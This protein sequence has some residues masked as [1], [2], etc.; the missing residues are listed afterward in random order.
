[1]MT[2]LAASA[3]LAL[4]CLAFMQQPTE[5]RPARVGA[6][7]PTQQAQ[8]APDERAAPDRTAPEGRPRGDAASRGRRMSEALT[9]E[10]LAEVIA[11]A[12][13]ISPEW[14]EGL[15]T[16]LAEDPDGLRQAIASAGPRLVGLAMLKRSHPELYALRIGTYFAPSAPR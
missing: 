11:V 10:E 16:R 14:G 3:A 8:S 2:N 9:V 7:A 15:R 4:G 1:M 12:Q 6:T 5:T 13:E